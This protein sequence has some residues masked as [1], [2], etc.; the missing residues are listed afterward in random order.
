VILWLT[1]GLAY[2][3]FVQRYVPRFSLLDTWFHDGNEPCSALP[4]VNRAT[5]DAAFEKMSNGESIEDP[6]WSALYNAILAVG[7]RVTLSADSPSTFRHSEQEGW[8]YFVNALNAQTE[9]LYIRTGL[10][11]V[12][13]TQTPIMPK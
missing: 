6:A 10:M 7:C 3:S 5:F 4:I 11:S 2:F 8:G 1:L 13:V 12:Q 9:L